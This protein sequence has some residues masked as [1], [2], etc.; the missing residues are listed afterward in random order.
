MLPGRDLNSF[1]IRMGPAVKYL[2]ETKSR[3]WIGKKLAP[4][5]SDDRLGMIWEGTDN[6]IGPIASG[7]E[8]TAFA[9]GELARNAMNAAD[10]K[11]YCRNGVEKLYPGFGS[12]RA[13]DNFTN[14]PS[15][16]WS[17]GGYSCPTLRQVTTAARKLY[18]ADGR[19]VWA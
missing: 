12:E 14:W 10:P 6:Q 17:L 8:M 9:G 3:F 16:D 4:S 19:L 11:E 1:T 5:A 13:A 18:K 7:A 15:E 2:G